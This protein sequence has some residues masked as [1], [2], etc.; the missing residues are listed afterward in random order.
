MHERLDAWLTAALGHTVQVNAVER[1]ST[2]HSRAMYRVELDF[3]PSLVLRLEQG[4]VFGTTGAEEY[5]VMDALGDV[6]FPVATVLCAEPTGAVLG[7]PFF[8]MEFVDGDPIGQE[9]RSLDD[10][11]AASLVATIDRLH[12]V[13]SADVFSAF[14]VAP[15]PAE[16]T[17]VLI[18]HWAGIYRRA[19][20]EL[21]PLL[22]E[23]VAWL[24][25]HAPP[26]DRLSVV[27]GDPGPGNFVQSHGRVVALTDWEFGHLGDPMEDWVYLALMRGA[28]TRARSEWLAL[29]ADVADI[30]V[31]EFEQRFWGAFNFFKGA[32]ANRSA[33]EVFR[34]RPA[35]PNL[36]IIGTA[37]HQTF[38][39]EMSLL[40]AAP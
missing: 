30:H 40:V 20:S 22:E 32:C 8:V 37:L 38:L 6:G 27:H 14:D 29:F 26:L 34:D 13:D 21:I 9:D 23:C 7:Q 15:S 12:R 16:A 4:G 10:P 17:H 11:T 1:M 3:G 25:Q 18:D 5:R 36:A 33:L 24:H 28:R 31:T 35:A 2:G 19:S 39:R